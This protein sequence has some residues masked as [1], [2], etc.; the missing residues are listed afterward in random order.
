MDVLTVDTLAQALQEPKRALLLKVLRTVGQDRC[1]A[2]LADTLQCED[3]GGMLTKDGT[4]RRTPG[5]VF[6]QLVK[7]RVTPQERRRL[8]PPPAAPHR[9]DHPA[10]QAQGQAQD[11]APALTWDEARSLMQTLATESPGEARTMKLTLIGR[12]GKVET[13][14][15]AVV[16]RMQ[17][18]PPGAL[19]RGLPPA[20]AQPPDDLERH[21]GPAAVEPGQG[22]PD[23][24]PGGPAHH[25]GVSPP[26]GHAAGTVGAELCQHAATA[27][28]EAGTAPAA[29]GDA[30][31]PRPFAQALR[32]PRWRGP[33]PPGGQ[34][35]ERGG[36]AEG[37][38][39]GGLEGGGGGAPGGGRGTHG[40]GATIPGSTLPFAYIHWL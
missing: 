24:Q 7:E 3:G 23:R 15:Q 8:F 29:D 19:P 17:G 27:G 20:P 30:L 22:E 35:I 37:G 34:S 28:T 21:G 10:Q 9:K 39:A 5:G 36:V 14:G 38:S 13:R 31:I 18:K 32:A 1:A 16:F 25:R 11:A 12:P 33:S 6:F 4:R 40:A 2:I 26:A